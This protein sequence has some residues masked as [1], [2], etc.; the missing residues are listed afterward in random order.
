[1]K[2]L[3]L[4]HRL[5]LEDLGEACGVSTIRDLQTIADRIEH[6][7]FSFLTITLPTLGKALESALASGRFAPQH[8]P[9]FS[10]GHG[11]LP[12]FM[13]G[14]FEQIF[15]ATNG[16]L[17]DVPRV[18]AI[19]AIRQVSYLW[20]RVNLPCTGLRVRKAYKKY[21]ECDKEVLAHAASRSED[22]SREFRRAAH[23]LFGNM[24]QRLGA[25]LDNGRLLPKH[26][27]GATADRQ[28]RN[29]RY[30][31]PQWTERLETLFPSLENAFP[32]Y[33]W[34]SSS[35]YQSQK[36]LTL[37]QEPPSRVTAVPKTL[38]TPRIIAMEPAHMMYVQQGFLEMFRRAMRSDQ[39]AFQFVCF[40]SQEPNQMLAKEGARDGLLATLDLSE[41]S[42]RV[43]IRH[44][45]DLL[46]WHPL[47]REGVF[48]CRSLKAEVPGHGVIPLA[49]FASMG[50]ALCFPLEALVFMTIVWIGLARSRNTPV[51][52]MDP[53]EFYGKVRIYGD[54]II[55]P[56]R[57][58]EVV[59]STLEAYG[60]KVNA[61]KSFWTGRF[62][63]SCGKDYYGEHDVSIVRMNHVFPKSQRESQ[64]IVSLVAF[65]NGLA[66]SSLPFERTLEWVDT[67]IGRF[68]P[69]PY[70]TEDSAVL[71]RIDPNRAC[72]ERMHPDWQVP[73]V[74]GARLVSRPPGDI[75]EGHGALMKFFLKRSASPEEDEFHLLHAGRDRFAKIRIG[76]GRP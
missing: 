65:R 47:L 39:N 69:F 72:A 12:R 40:D 43:S 16:V 64:E 55:V 70:V 56:V 60:L 29:G 61:D 8:A 49:K 5:L 76:W 20:K 74:R 26:G 33:G 24:F 53:K 34:Y 18:E 75:L 38:K 58:A 48:A 13:G 7:G 14:F 54:D 63:E 35:E 19:I 17:L 41:A 67:R 6:E 46:A 9:A 25:D 32:N 52:R 68:I 50:S 10:T 3:I 66:L 62:R 4:F 27:S 36:L 30:Y 37:D 22:S 28:T 59:I 23:F 73:L 1:M 51:D 44:V 42:D 31:L 21:V 11:S 71:G 15:D 45:E 57:D 2:S